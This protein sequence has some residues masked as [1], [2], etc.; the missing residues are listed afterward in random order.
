MLVPSFGSV[1]DARARGA[2]RSVKFAVDSYFILASHHIMS[3]TEKPL[4]YRRMKLPFDEQVRKLAT[5]GRESYVTHTGIEKL[6]KG[7]ERD[8][9]PDAYSR[10]AQYRARKTLCGTTTQYGV[11]VEPLELQLQNGKWMT[12]GVQNPLAMLAFHCSESEHFANLVYGASLKFPPSPERP[13][14]IILYQ[15]GVD[16]SDGLAKNHS[17]KSAVFYWTFAEF[18]LD[19]L[20]HEESCDP[21]KERSIFHS[22]DKV[23]F[24]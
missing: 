17:R 4:L 20:A 24:V 13:W 18:G 6:M 19:G 11:L 10:N 16:P 9:L 21:G 22:L 12:C 23:F 15:D 8:G 7:I 14:R 1:H 2:R 5:L 3:T